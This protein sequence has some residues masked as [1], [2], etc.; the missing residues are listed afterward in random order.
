M[1]D[2]ELMLA[3]FIEW[4]QE[5]ALRPVLILVCAMLLFNL[6]AFI[7]KIR[8]AIRGVL[9]FLL[10]WDKSWK[11]PQDP[12][13][14]FGPHLSQALPVQRKTVYFVRHGESTWNDT[15]NKGKHRSAAMFVIGFF[16][17][18]AKA[19][20]YEVYLLLTGKIDS[21]FYDAPLSH[22]G[23][24]QAE[25]LAAFLK[26][27]PL[28]GP[29]AEHIKILRGEEGSPPSK[30]LCSSLRRAVSTLVV[31]FKDRLSRKP[32]DKI[33]IIP[34]LQEISRNPDTLSITPAQTPIQAS[35]IEKGSKEIA[36]FQNVFNSQLDMGLHM[37]N[38]P[39]DT[40]GLKRMNEFCEFLYSQKDEYFVVG[41]H[42]IWFRSFFRMFLP[43]SVHHASKEK[44]IVN[45]GV[46]TFELMKAE[47]R[48]GPRYMIDPKTIQV[49]YG[50]FD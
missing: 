18:L 22:L 40:N 26:D 31:G 41:G 50:G 21:W 28:D 12:G 15:F 13:S 8:M 24:S 3:S 11:K 23:L 30:F 42:S 35:W 17:G 44:K 47:T 39:L 33:L 38:K 45:G 25:E 19:L 9:Y 6:P 1:S 4:V 20:I 10:C 16:P 48:R 43:Y 2:T 7:Y 46:V 14:I 37:G 34:S 27:K 36:D 29:E 32:D 5:D 49:V